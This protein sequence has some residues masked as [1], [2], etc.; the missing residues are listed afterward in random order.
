MNVGE[1]EWQNLVKKLL[2]NSSNYL[3]YKLKL[4]LHITSN[5]KKKLKVNQAWKKLKWK[6]LI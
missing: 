1:L 4:G 6:T 5:Y 2:T 3:K